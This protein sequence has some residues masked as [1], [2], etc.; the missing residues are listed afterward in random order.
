MRWIEVRW[1]N[2]SSKW[3][4]A[5]KEKV[6]V[7]NDANTLENRVE[8]IID[9]DSLCMFLHVCACYPPSYFYYSIASCYPSLHPPWH[10]CN[11]SY[12][13]I[14]PPSSVLNPPAYQQLACADSIFPKNQNTFHYIYKQHGQID[15]TEINRQRPMHPHLPYSSVLF[16]FRLLFLVFVPSFRRSPRTWKDA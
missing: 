10:T 7:G 15:T 6:W 16:F 14:H 4:P 12:L 8:Y 11:V 3:E 2:G 13:L 9:Y 5:V 1:E